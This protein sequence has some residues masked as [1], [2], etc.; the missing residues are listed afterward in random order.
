MPLRILRSQGCGYLWPEK[1]EEAAAG[2]QFCAGR[3][4]PRPGMAHF[5]NLLSPALV[6]SALTTAKFCT[7]SVVRAAPANTRRITIIA[8]R[9]SPSKQNVRGVGKLEPF[10]FM[11]ERPGGCIGGWR[12]VGKFWTYDVRPEHIGWTSSVPGG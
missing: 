6:T 11:R 2:D 12:R 5:M 9:S 1:T 3:E 8:Q 4:R 10:L 7:R